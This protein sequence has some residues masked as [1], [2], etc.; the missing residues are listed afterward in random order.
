MAKRAEKPELPKELEFDYIKSN[1]FR[2]IKADG[3]FG[4]L[5]PNGSVH[6][7]LYSERQALPTKIFHKVEPP[8]TLGPEIREKR[9]GTKAI[10]RELEVDAVMDIGAA[11]VL[12]NWLDDKITQF[13]QIIGPLPPE[14]LPTK[15]N[16]KG[17]KK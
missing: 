7:A 3:A 10:V 17:T 5:A 12:R 16:G 15:S 2:V 14:V 8:G 9:Q 6:M 11:V 1:F 13:Q 4:G